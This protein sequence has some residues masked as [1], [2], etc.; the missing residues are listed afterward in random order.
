MTVIRSRDL[1]DKGH[2]VFD[3]EQRMLALERVDD[4]GRLERFRLGHS[5]SRLVEQHDLGVL[6][7]QHSKLEPLGLT[8]AEIGGDHSRL[9]GQAD[10]FKDLGDAV[11]RFARKSESEI[12]QNPR[13]AAAHDFQIALDRQILKHAG[14]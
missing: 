5:G 6:N 7:H 12:V 13:V 14:I 4:L 8:M 11:L 2:V 9:L 10:E 1:A 3:D